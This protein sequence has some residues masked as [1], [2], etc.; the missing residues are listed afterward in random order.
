MSA[1]VGLGLVAPGG[2]IAS[3]G[4]RANA[5]DE[6]EAPAALLTTAPK[7]GKSFT[8][9]AFCKTSAY[10]APLN[11]FKS[12]SSAS[13]IARYAYCMLSLINWRKS[14]IV[15]VNRVSWEQS[16]ASRIN[17]L[18]W[19]TEVEVDE[20][21]VGGEK[22]YDK[23]LGSRIGDGFRL[24]YSWI[25]SKDQSSTDLKEYLLDSLAMSIRRARGASGVCTM[26]NSCGLEYGQ[27]NGYKGRRKRCAQSV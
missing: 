10:A 18:N 22:V 8:I 4:G 5:K 2:A 27:H 16:W 23:G 24:T 11:P 9:I 6:D 12:S 17:E 7:I 1:P 21:E 26:A 14:V 13:V 19:S 25:A 15:V 3:S 20:V